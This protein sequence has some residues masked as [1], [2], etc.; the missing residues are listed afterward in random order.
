MPKFF[1]SMDTAFWY[2]HIYS[3]CVGIEY[4]LLYMLVRFTCWISLK[5]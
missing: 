5:S 2:R 3:D 1:I 4:A